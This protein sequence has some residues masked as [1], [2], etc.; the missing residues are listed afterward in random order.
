MGFRARSLRSDFPVLDGETGDFAQLRTGTF[1][2]SG[3]ATATSAKLQ[4]ESALP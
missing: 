1:W 2:R 3:V 4:K